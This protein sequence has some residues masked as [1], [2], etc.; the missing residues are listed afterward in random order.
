[1][2]DQRTITAVYEANAAI[3]LVYLLSYE[4]W[5]YF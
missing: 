2:N 1:M 3:L 4:A 5:F